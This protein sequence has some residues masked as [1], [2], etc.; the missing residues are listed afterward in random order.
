MFAWHLEYIEKIIVESTWLWRTAVFVLLLWYMLCGNVTHVCCGD[1]PLTPAPLCLSLS[2]CPHRSTLPKSGHRKYGPPSVQLAH[3]LTLWQLDFHSFYCVSVCVP[4]RKTCVLIFGLMCFFLCFFSSPPYWR[5]SLK[6]ICKYSAAS[7]RLSIPVGSKQKWIHTLLI[8][9]YCREKLHEAHSDLQKKKE[10]IDDLEPKVDGN[11]KSFLKNVIFC[12]FSISFCLFLLLN[13]FFIFL[14][15]S[16][17][18]DRWTPGEP[19]EEG[20]G[21]EADGGAIQTLCGEGENG[22]ST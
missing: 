21:H 11:S 19:A 5:K 16:G 18:E 14:P 8:C 20:W 1:S 22:Q 2:A 9:D 7:Y 12:S 17:K 4:F 3:D 15:L 6:N 10:V 13:T